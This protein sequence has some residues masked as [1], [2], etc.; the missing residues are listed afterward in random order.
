M[1]GAGVG[2]GV[3]PDGVVGVSLGVVDGVLLGVLAGVVRALL[4]GWAEGL[5]DAFLLGVAPWLPDAPGFA[6]PPGLVAP[7][8][9]EARAAPADEL[10]DGSRP[11]VG[12][13]LAG[14]PAGCWF[15]V[16]APV[17]A[18]ETSSA[19]RPALARTPAPTPRAAALRRCGGLGW[20]AS[21]GSDMRGGTFHSSDR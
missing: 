1:V 5:V 17:N 16:G 11:R 7:A 18:P 12:V 19:T 2:G 6:A 10:G 20:P 9:L 8:L 15:A 14:V 4:L 13:L 21:V 3:L